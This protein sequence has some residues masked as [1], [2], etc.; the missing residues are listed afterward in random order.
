MLL[1][2]SEKDF[3]SALKLE[4]CGLE[5]VMPGQQAS[6]AGME[7]T[8]PFVGHH[9]GSSYGTNK[10]LPNHVISDAFEVICN[11]RLICLS[12]ADVDMHPHPMKE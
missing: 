4:A 11:A 1:H 2:A 7:E 10:E 8:R 6:S 9:I 3:E 12:F 5:V